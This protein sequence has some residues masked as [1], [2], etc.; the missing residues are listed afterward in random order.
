MSD[1]QDH[2]RRGGDD[3][4]ERALDELRVALEQLAARMGAGFREDLAQIRAIAASV[5][6][7]DLTAD[8]EALRVDV[9]TL[10]GRDSAAELRDDVATLRAELDR[11]ASRE[12]VTLGMAPL[13]ATLDRLSSRLD[14]DTGRTQVLARF[15][16][17]EARLDTLVNLPADLRAHMAD[18]LA[19]LDGD[20]VMREIAGV[21]RQLGDGDGTLLEQLQD[22]LADVASGE[23]VGALWD[24]VR[25]LRADIPE[26][27]PTPEP[28]APV[29]E[30]DPQLATLTDELAVLRTELAE[31]LVVEPSDALSASLDALRAEVDELRGSLGELGSSPEPVAAPDL[32]GLADRSSVDAVAEQ[33]TSLRS[34]VAAQLEG[35]RTAVAELPGEAEPVEDDR[36]AEL[37]ERLTSLQ[38]G[39]DDVRTRL[40]EVAEAADQTPAPAPVLTDEPDRADIDTLADQVAALR[41]FIASELDTL[42]QTV[43]ARL[44]AAAE[45]TASTVAAAAAQPAPQPAGEVQAGIDPETVAL[46]RDEIRTSGAIGD[47][48]V[49]ALREE[50]KALRRRIAVKAS[51]RVLDEAQLAQIADAVA[52]RLAE[53]GDEG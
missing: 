1:D 12:D 31:G 19:G 20:A 51:E 46:L 49:D 4:T 15:E 38:V 53:G 25:Q 13:H 32:S 41:D 36:D 50:L 22:N 29:R 27:V 37:L 43:A 3:G 45:A 48:V 8:I 34:F 6:E 28:V 44:D 35:V 18:A 11:F 16:A 24:E 42:R 23:V 33:V 2:P 26:L 5:A 21:R 14:D 30:P 9:A 39:V 10:V 47:Q 40:D 17:L 7:R 52:A